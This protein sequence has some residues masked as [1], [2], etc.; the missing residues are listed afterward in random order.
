MAT[1]GTGS[2]NASG[3]NKAAN[4]IASIAALAAIAAAIIAWMSLDASK[5]NNTIAVAANASASAANSIANEGLALAKKNEARLDRQ[6]AEGVQLGEAPSEMKD[7]YPLPD[8]VSIWFVVYNST[9]KPIENVWVADAEQRSIKIQGIQ[10]CTMYALDAGFH[11]TDLYFSDQDGLYWHRPYNGQPE[12]MTKQE[13]PPMP[14]Q[15]T[16]GNSPW[17]HAIENCSTG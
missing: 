3:G 8:G 9:N 12:P 13:F 17:D 10:P 5:K 7:L 14:A 15:D 4:V 1:V 16:G 2:G 6:S 11:P